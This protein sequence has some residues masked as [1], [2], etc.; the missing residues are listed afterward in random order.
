MS[1]VGSDIPKTIDMII[2]GTPS[3]FNVVHSIFQ[4][5][6]HFYKNSSLCTYYLKYIREIYCTTKFLTIFPLYIGGRCLN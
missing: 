6:K 2:T 5:I 1:A 3:Q 4:H